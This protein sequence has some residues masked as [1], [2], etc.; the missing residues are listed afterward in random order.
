MVTHLKLNSSL[1]PLATLPAGFIEFKN[2]ADSEGKIRTSFLKLSNPL[3]KKYQRETN[4]MNEVHDW[5]KL[6]SI[7]VNLKKNSHKK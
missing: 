1:I 5:K 6:F 4:I 2:V 3:K 7:G